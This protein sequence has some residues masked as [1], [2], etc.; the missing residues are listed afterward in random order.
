MPRASKSSKRKSDQ[1]AGAPPPKKPK[2]I[3]NTPLHDVMYKEYLREGYFDEKGKTREYFVQKLLDKKCFDVNAFNY[4]GQTPYD[5]AQKAR[6]SFSFDK[7]LDDNGFLPANKL[8]EHLRKF[9]EKRME[10]CKPTEFDFCVQD[11]GPEIDETTGN[12]RVHKLMLHDFG[13]DPGNKKRRAALLML[14]PTLKKGDL[15]ELNK[16][17]KTPYDLARKTWRNA[18]SKKRYQDDPNV[19]NHPWYK[20]EFDFDL[21]AYW[22]DLDYEFLD[23]LKRHGLH[24]KWDLQYTLRNGIDQ[25]M[26]NNDVSKQMCDELLQQ[27]TVEHLK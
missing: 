23:F 16:A 27:Y 10:E 3:G 4:L 7:F 15:N 26:A 1:A 22:P 21:D 19:V 11:L 14:L 17:K 18:E 13:E 8:P 25:F 6:H 24:D 2:F 5:I 12:N 20:D 9:Q